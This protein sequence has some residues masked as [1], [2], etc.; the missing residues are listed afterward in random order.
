MWDEEF[1]CWEGAE[2]MPCTWTATYIAWL[3][4]W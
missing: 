1:S 3:F 4:V 2:A